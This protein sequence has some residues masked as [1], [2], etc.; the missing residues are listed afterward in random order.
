MLHVVACSWS[1]NWQCRC[2]VVDVVEVIGVVDV[3]DVEFLVVLVVG[4]AVVVDSVV[5]V[6]LVVVMA[7][8]GCG[9]LVCGNGLRLWA[10]KGWVLLLGKLRCL[11]CCFVRAEA[12]LR[13]VI[14]LMLWILWVLLWIRVPTVRVLTDSLS[15]SIFSVLANGK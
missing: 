13:F 12:G 3:V 11:G 5:V 15:S 14:L 6:L 9:R 7:V 10:G 4:F 8:H 1:G 2:S